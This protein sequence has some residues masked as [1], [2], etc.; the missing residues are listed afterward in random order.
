MT[1]V[2]LEAGV[3]P[4][5]TRLQNVVF[6]FYEIFLIGDQGLLFS[7]KLGSWSSFPKLSP[8]LEQ[9]LSHQYWKFD[10]KK[11]AEVLES[12]EDIPDETLLKGVLGLYNDCEWN[13]LSTVELFN[14]LW[15]YLVSD[16]IPSRDEATGKRV[17]LYNITT[18]AQARSAAKEHQL[19]IINISGDGRV[20][21][22]QV[23]SDVNSK[24]KFKGNVV[25]YNLPITQNSE[26]GKATNK[27]LKKGGWVL[28]INRGSWSLVL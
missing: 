8:H 3:P 10:I 19:D 2:S 17:K 16:Q 5:Q 11:V 6:F 9:N 23:I 13:H 26:P 24:L 14:L 4:Q 7:I 27:L 1:T 20:V 21:K 15:F 28:F 18:I 22:K 25:N 12:S